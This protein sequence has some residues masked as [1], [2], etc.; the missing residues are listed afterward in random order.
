MMEANVHKRF[1]WVRFYEQYENAGIVCLK[2]GI[3]RPTLR[4]KE[5]E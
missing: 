5:L 4:M 3:F 2:C 1:E